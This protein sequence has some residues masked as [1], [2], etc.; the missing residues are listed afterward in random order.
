MGV[1]PVGCPVG[2]V[3]SCRV[4][5]APPIPSSHEQDPQVGGRFRRVPGRRGRV[6]GPRDDTSHAPGTVAAE[7]PDPFGR[8]RS[9][10]LTDEQRER[11]RWA[12]QILESARIS[13]DGTL[14]ASMPGDA[15]DVGAVLALDLY[16]RLRTSSSSLEPGSLGG[17]IDVPR[18]QQVLTE[19]DILPPATSSTPG[20]S[21]S[22]L[23]E[24][25]GTSNL[26]FDPQRALVRCLGGEVAHPIEQ[27]LAVLVGKCLARWRKPFNAMLRGSKRGLVMVDTELYG[28]RTMTDS[29]DAIRGVVMSTSYPKGIPHG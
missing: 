18:F 22:V 10:D 29:G 20:R 9:A 27:V 4:W 24:T 13:E 3:S 28:L 12:M 16:H 7:S 19:D 21:L 11:L 6:R 1:D 2:I 14:H 8:D 26:R 23:L 25:P 15:G 17:A 5:V